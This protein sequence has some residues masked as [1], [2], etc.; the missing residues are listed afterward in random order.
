MDY[1]QCRNYNKYFI[2]SSILPSLIISKR[3]AY[4]MKIWRVV[5]RE[6]IVV[7]NYVPKPNEDK[8]QDCWL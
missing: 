3:Q 2:F 4:M 5:F 1:Y 7:Y 6:Y 8:N